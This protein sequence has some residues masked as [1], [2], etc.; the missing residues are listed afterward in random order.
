MAEEP[1]YRIAQLPERVL[2]PHP[3][4]LLNRARDGR[5]SRSEVDDDE[6]LVA[7]ES[8]ERDDLDIEE[9]CGTDVTPVRRQER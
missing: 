4:S 5:N 6:D 8:A 7:N 9:I 1:V 3:V 2:N